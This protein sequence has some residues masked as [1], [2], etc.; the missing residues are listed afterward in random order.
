MKF[1]CGKSYSETHQKLKNWHE[2]FAWYPVKVADND[3]RWLEKVQRKGT[4]C[5]Y[6]IDSTWFWDYKEIQ[7][8]C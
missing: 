3:C 4:F 1:N 2:W 6:G 5:N 7:N 8:G